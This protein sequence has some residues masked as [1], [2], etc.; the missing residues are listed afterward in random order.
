LDNSPVSVAAE[1]A[2]EV[3]D[4]AP[5]AVAIEVGLMDFVDVELG[6]GSRV[7]ASERV[8]VVVFVDVLDC[9]DVEVG[10]RPSP[11]RIRS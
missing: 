2:E 3:L 11:R 5:V 4:L 10:T 7:P 8:D 9:V 6:E 1:V